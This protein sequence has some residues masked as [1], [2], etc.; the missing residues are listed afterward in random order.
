MIRQNLA[1]LLFSLD[2]A[3]V[4]LWA[5]PST[6]K[7][8]ASL[9]ATILEL[10]CTAVAALLLY[11][12]H[13]YSIR[14][15][16]L[17]SLYLFV[18][19]LLGLAHARSL[20]LLPPQEFA[21]I[22]RIF[23][24]T[25]VARAALLLLEEFPKTSFLIQDSGSTPVESASGPLNRSVFWWLNPLFATGARRL[26]HVQDLGSID[27]KFDSARL[28]S[29]LRDVWSRCDKS[30]K[31]C[32]LSS[33]LIAYKIGYLTPVIPRLCLAGFSF[34]QPFLIKR[35]IEYVSQPVGLQSND[36]AG[37]LVAAAFLIYSGLAVCYLNLDSCWPANRVVADIEMHI[38]PYHLPIEHKAS[39]RP[40][41]FDL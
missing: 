1:G 24:A 38:Q 13:K 14:P 2:L 7:N 23:T 19:V 26:I 33:T 10:L 31:H 37:G 27:R 4:V 21:D 20:F 15:S 32:L 34:S 16:K 29:A 3:L 18:S 39:R 9:P 12:E 41:I 22:A 28:L 30:A 11:A 40:R 36:T 35:V 5:W 17:L 25:L 8:A 6:S